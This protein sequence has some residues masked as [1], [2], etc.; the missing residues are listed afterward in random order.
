MA[1][2]EKEMSEGIGMLYNTKKP[3][4]AIGGTLSGV[5]NIGKGVVAGVASVGVMTAVGAK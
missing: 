5:G 3:A 1:R 2:E 4:S